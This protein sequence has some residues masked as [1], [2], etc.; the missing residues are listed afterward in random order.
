MNSHEQQG[1]L[2]EAAASI[3]RAC[4]LSEIVFSEDY[5]ETPEGQAAVRAAFG[6]ADTVLESVPDDAAI[7]ALSDLNKNASDVEK[8]ES[9]RATLLELEMSTTDVDNK[10]H[11]IDMQVDTKTRLV[12]GRLTLRALMNLS[13]TAEPAV[14]NSA[15]INRAD[16]QPAKPAVTEVAKPRPTVAIDFGMDETSGMPAVYIGSRRIKLA[17]KESSLRHAAPKFAALSV[18][19]ELVDGE[20]IS[21]NE[22]WTR[23]FTSVLGV[24]HAP[25]FDRDVMR[26]VREF[27]TNLTYRKQQMFA[28]NNK[29]GLSSAYEVNPELKYDV[30]IGAESDDDVKRFAQHLVELGVATPEVEQHPEAMPV[31]L[32]KPFAPIETF[33]AE[34]DNEPDVPV[35]TEIVEEPIDQPAETEVDSVS[36]EIVERFAE[37]M[38][39]QMELYAF[40]SKIYSAMPNFAESEAIPESSMLHFVF[41]IV[42]GMLECIEENFDEEDTKRLE[43]N[44]S[45]DAL[46]SEVADK[47]ISLTENDALLNDLAENNIADIFG[48]LYGEK[49]GIF[50]EMLIDTILDMDDEET[51]QLR[52]L[53]AFNPSTRI[54]VDNGSFSSGVTIV[55]VEYDTGDEG[56]EMPRSTIEDEIEAVPAMPPATV[57][58]EE[59]VDTPEAE[60]EVVPEAVAEQNNDDI[61]DERIEHTP[62]SPEPIEAQEAKTKSK[63]ELEEQH[64][65]AVVGRIANQLLAV[66][67]GPGD[68]YSSRQLESEFGIRRNHIVNARENNM[69]S[70]DTKK[71]V[72]FRDAIMLLVAR[73]S[74]A[75][76]KR[77]LTIPR[78]RKLFRALAK[79]TEVAIAEAQEDK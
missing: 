24:E 51:A 40:L 69:I 10:L 56:D 13:G 6:V 53:I 55:G 25:V 58:E 15:S 54:I 76:I 44:V 22:L 57:E 66:G 27:L 63:T 12:A 59:Q 39:S 74:D 16:Q 30:V 47:L 52:E 21:V 20:Q 65:R 41:D 31:S 42:D 8:L 60:T 38:P 17:S 19:T 29:R 79:S 48:Q 73:E 72:S 14:Y 28:H 11:E 35:V 71:D 61:R 4:R 78:M 46:R 37:V 7:S 64:I 49:L 68:R 70:E 26:N 3:E 75:E 32:E 9:L 2:S 23:M 1:H 77:L 5:D 67:F 45:L 34:A 50:G 18:L 62:A 33:D 36:D 43:S